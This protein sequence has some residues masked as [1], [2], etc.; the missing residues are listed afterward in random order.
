M[1]SPAV[2]VA[3]IRIVLADDEP[4]VRAGIAMLLSVQ[5]DMEVVGEAAD[6]LEAVALARE[7]Q[8]DIVIMDLQMPNLDGVGATHRLT[9]DDFAADQKHTVK[10]LVL[11]TFSNDEQVY[12]ALRAG[13]SGF[14]LKSGVP[15]DLASAVR[16]IHAGNAYL[17]PAVTR[18]VIADLTHRPGPSPRTPGLLDRLTPREREILQLMAHGLPNREIAE[19]LFLAEATVK[20]HV[21]RVIMKLGVDDR[22]QA[23]VLAY[24]NQLVELP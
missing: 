21:C 10:V 24:R 19:R 18:S 1:E 20:T 12:A 11:T 2:D 22:T 5:P 7:L 17:H 3:T 8:P 6:G 23:V 13:A 15:T 9:A 16:E 14:L 4:L